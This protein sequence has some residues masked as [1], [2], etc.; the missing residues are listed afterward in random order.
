MP[1]EDMTGT[2]GKGQ[3][4]GGI[5]GGSPAIAMFGILC[6]ALSNAARLG[7]IGG[8]GGGELGSGGREIGGGED[9]RREERD[10]ELRGLVVTEVGIGGAGG[11]GG[12]CGREEDRRKERRLLGWLPIFEGPERSVAE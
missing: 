4:G 8:I 5:G 10:T 12:D 1:S 7:F 11:T 6:L 3:L 2:F 9:G